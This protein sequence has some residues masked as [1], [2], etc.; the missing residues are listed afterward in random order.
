MIHHPS[1]LGRQKAKGKRQKGREAEPSFFLFTFAFFL[2]TFAFRREAATERSS[3]IHLHGILLTDRDQDKRK[4]DQGVPAGSAVAPLD[5]AQITG[6]ATKSHSTN[7]SN[8]R[9]QSS[10]PVGR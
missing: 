9:C 6:R 10:L 1:L 5:V 7:N 3:R 8:A 4:P 2:L